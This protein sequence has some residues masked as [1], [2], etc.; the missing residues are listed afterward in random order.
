[1]EK[2]MTDSRPEA[3]VCGS[4][5]SVLLSDLARDSAC[6]RDLNWRC[7]LTSEAEPDALAE[8]LVEQGWTVRCRHMNLMVF[9]HPHGH[10]IAWVTSTGRVQIRVALEIDREARPHRAVEIFEMLSL[11]LRQACLRNSKRS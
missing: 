1:M 3:P 11:A 7:D 5:P 8:A 9:R 4:D 10:E 2:E 6:C